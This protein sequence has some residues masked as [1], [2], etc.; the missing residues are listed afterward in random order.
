MPRHIE[1]PKMKLRECEECAFDIDIVGRKKI[2]NE[3][4]LIMTYECEH[5]W[6]NNTWQDMCCLCGID[7]EYLDK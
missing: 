5:K 1:R 6:H 2:N 7:A 4:K 3:L